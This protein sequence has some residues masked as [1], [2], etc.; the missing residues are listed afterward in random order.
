MLTVL[1]YLL[2]GSLFY[3]WIDPEIGAKSSARAFIWVFQLLAT[4]GWGDSHA[5]TSLSQAFTVLY[6][7]AGIPML[8][9]AYANLGR[10]ITEF[11]CRQG[12]ALWRRLFKGANGKGQDVHEEEVPQQR[13]PLVI[14]ANLLAL[15]QCIGL[16]IYSV[17]LKDWPIISTIYFRC[18]VITIKMPFLLSITTMATSGFGDFHPDTDSWM[19]VSLES[20]NAISAPLKCHSSFLSLL[21]C[22]SKSRQ[23]WPSSTSPWALSSS[24]PCS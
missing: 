5:S 22:H 13:L 3:L 20:A 19:E 10:L 8:F 11:C 15:H 6:V 24:R 23:L 2:L 1:A 16:L 4:I 9:S 18:A 7:L 12:P 14:I 21:K 17:W